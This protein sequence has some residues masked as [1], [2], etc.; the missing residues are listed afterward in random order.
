MLSRFVLGGMS[1]TLESYP[2]W[3]QDLLRLLHLRSLPQISL[4]IPRRLYVVWGSTRVAYRP[5]AP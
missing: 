4:L 1:I 3:W 2:S 5:G